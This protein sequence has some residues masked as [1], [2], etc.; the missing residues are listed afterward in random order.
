M[1]KTDD[2][3]ELIRLRKNKQLF[4]ENDI[5]KQAGSDN[6]TKRSIYQSKHR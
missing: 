6:I 2:E 3:K 4:L 1:I 5:L